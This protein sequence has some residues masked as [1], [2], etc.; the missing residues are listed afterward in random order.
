QKSQFSPASSGRLDLA[1]AQNLA[2]PSCYQAADEAMA[3][4][5]NV[6]NCVYFRTPVPGLNGTQIGN[7]IFY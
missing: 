6:G 2:T 5:T 7:H 1:L 4:S 3:G